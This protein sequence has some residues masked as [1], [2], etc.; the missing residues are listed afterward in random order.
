M[1][2]WREYGFPHDGS[3]FMVKT[4]DGF[5]GICRIVPEEDEWDSSHNGRIT[6]YR[7]DQRQRIKPSIIQRWKP[8]E[9]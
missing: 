9:Y 2:E 6:V 1:S 7:G 5:V 8:I 3:Y 4:D